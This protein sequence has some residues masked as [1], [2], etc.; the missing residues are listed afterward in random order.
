MA[1]WQLAI[2]ALPGID[3]AGLA[4]LTSSSVAS[5]RG[6]GG[7]FQQLWQSAGA[8]WMIMT[9][10]ACEFSSLPVINVG[11]QEPRETQQ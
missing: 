8:V 10:V 1:V 7:N 6:N 3:A 5:R 11:R 4:A 2:I 9:V